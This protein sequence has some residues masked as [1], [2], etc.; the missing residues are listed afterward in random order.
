MSAPFVTEFV[1]SGN[2]QRIHIVFRR[3]TEAELFMDAS[4][5]YADVAGD[6]FEAGALEAATLLANCADRFAR[7]AASVAERTP[8]GGQ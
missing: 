1:N 7:H 6:L 3:P 2:G 8:G 5:R 4:N